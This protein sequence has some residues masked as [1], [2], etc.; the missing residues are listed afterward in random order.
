MRRV[1][2]LESMSNLMLRSNLML[3]KGNDRDDNRYMPGDLLIEMHP[4]WK[5][6]TF[7]PSY[8]TPAQIEEYLNLLPCLR[9][10]KREC[11]CER[12]L[13]RR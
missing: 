9:C 13:P 5:D 12:L 7:M 1:K 8:L 10:G 6:K 2:Q 4:E 3:D 11:A